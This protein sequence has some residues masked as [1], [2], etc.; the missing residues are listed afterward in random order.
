MEQIS[1]Q[2]TGTLTNDSTLIIR[3]A[4][5][6]DCLRMLEL[7][8]EL[9]VFERAPQEVTLTMEHFIKSGFGP[10]PVWWALVA[11]ADGYIVGFC[12]VLY[13]LFNLERAK[14]VP[15][16]FIGNRSMAP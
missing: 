5:Q 11:E 15:G 2:H 13:P 8:N 14:N 3:A 12:F 9:A 7:V 10:N 6:Q 1:Q 16:R 4:T